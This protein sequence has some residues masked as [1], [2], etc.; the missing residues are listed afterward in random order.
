[1]GRDMGLC[2]RIDTMWMKVVLRVDRIREHTLKSL[3][4]AFVDDPDTIT[5]LLHRLADAAPGAE[6]DAVVL[7][8]EAEC[9][10]DDAE[11]SIDEADARRLG[12]E[13]GE[14]AELTMSARM[15][16]TAAKVFPEQRRGEA[17]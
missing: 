8:L 2:A 5:E 13:L 14:A 17:A 4:E 9:A 1:M 3:A 6:F 10:M 11:V 15:K 7:D 16:A 12:R